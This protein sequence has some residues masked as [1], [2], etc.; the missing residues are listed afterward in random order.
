MSISAILIQWGLPIPGR[1]RLALEEFSS[2]MQWT[3]KLAT[4]RKI[5][6]VGVYGVRAG[7]QQ[8]LSGFAIIEGDDAQI[9]T[10][11]ASDEFRAR[12]QRTMTVVQNLRIEPCEA[13]A[14][15]A[16]RMANYATALQQ[17][18]L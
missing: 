5:E 16:T 10:V 13:G 2:F 14:A 7:T 15:M 12:S 9:A 3:T 6:R 1:E 8:L 18:K 11:L 4:E 17:L